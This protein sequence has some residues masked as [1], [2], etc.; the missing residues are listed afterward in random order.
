L[1]DRA[2]AAFQQQDVAPDS[3]M[4]A[5]S[6]APPDKAKAA[7]PMDRETAPVLGEDPGL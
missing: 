5:D 6:L 2:T 3:L 1:A 7:A 4:L